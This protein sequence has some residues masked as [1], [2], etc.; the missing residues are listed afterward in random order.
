MLSITFYGKFCCFYKLFMPKL[1]SQSKHEESVPMLT[2][3][4]GDP[5]SLHFN[6]VLHWMIEMT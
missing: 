2:E 4:V 1:L 5:R 6:K 3:M